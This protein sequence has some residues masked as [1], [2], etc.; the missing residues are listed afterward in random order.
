MGLEAVE[1]VMSVE[2]NFGIEITDAEAAAIETVGQ[3][4]DA[5]AVK[6]GEMGRQNVNKHI[7]LDQLRTLIQFHLS[8]KPAD[9]TP[10]VRFRELYDFL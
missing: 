5:I 1:L 6:H 2:E 9:I 3:L 10:E 4:A 8:A 7:I